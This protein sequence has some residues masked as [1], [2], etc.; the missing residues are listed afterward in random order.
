VGILLAFAPFIIFAIV[1]RFVG[2]QI[3]LVAGASVSAILLL[4]DLITPNRSPKI[5]EI[6][7]FIL[8]CGLALYGWLALPNWTII[9]VRLCVDA[10]LLAIVVLSMLVRRPFTL[11]YARE[12]VAREH[13]G[14]P[15]FIRT[16]YVITAIWA[17][18]F[19]LM[20][21]AEL[22]LLYAPNLPKRAGVIVIV[23]A[24]V[25]AVKF[26]GWYPEHIRSQPLPP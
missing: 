6:G 19:A 21:I 26:T 2:S 22:A 25:G 15:E 5:L 16:N 24:L 17:L 8:F 7:T 20:V 14:S 9:G 11:Q 1:D 12:T 3:G 23:V 10:G 4:R 13:W 18:A